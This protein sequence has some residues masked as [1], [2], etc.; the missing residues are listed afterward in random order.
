MERVKV[1]VDEMPQ[2]PLLCPFAEL[3]S[4]SDPNM[5]LWTCALQ[6]YLIC[7]LT[8]GN[9]CPSLIEFKRGENNE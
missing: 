4:Y 3:A 7:N 6:M 1:Y 2:S 9:E 5:P 8:F